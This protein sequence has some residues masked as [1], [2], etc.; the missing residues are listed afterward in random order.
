[1]RKSSHFKWLSP[2]LA[3]AEKGGAV[4]GDACC[5]FVG[6]PKLERFLDPIEH[7]VNAVG[8]MPLRGLAGDED[9]FARVFKAVLN[10]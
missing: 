8:V 7:I 4:G 9:I 1:M 5:V 10:P 3:V 6:P 2:F